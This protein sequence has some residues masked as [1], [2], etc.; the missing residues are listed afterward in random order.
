[1]NVACSS[2]I[3][4]RKPQSGAVPEK[5]KHDLSN[6]YLFIIFDTIKSVLIDS[7]R[8]QIILAIKSGTRPYCSRQL[9]KSNN[10]G[11]F[12]I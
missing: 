1:M 7:D 9:N 8:E 2:V 3:N 12:F 5:K 11:A 10:P 6:H 4:L